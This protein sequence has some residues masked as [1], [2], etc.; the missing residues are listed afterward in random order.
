[1]K[2]TEERFSRRR[3]QTGGGEI[4]AGSSKCLLLL[5]LKVCISDKGPYSDPEALLL[6]CSE[7]QAAHYD[8]LITKRKKT[9]QDKKKKL[10]SVFRTED[11]HTI[12][13]SQWLCLLTLPPAPTPARP[14]LS[15]S[16]CLLRLPVSYFAALHS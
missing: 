15:V 4:K 2:A 13:P 14:L 5:I 1:M 7:V 3:E 16:K 12:S 8:H 6:N 11:K 9:E 10:I